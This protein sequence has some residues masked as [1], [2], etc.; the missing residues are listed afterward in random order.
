V[1][2]VLG[3]RYIEIG[4]GQID[5][6]WLGGVVAFQG[7]SIAFAGALNLIRLLRLSKGFLVFM[8]ILETYMFKVLSVDYHEVGTEYYNL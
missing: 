3:H 8:F 6:I 5:F 4:G 1:V 2:P 7:S